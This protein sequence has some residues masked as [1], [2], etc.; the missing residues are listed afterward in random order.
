MKLF[1]LL[2]L[3]TMCMMCTIGGLTAQVSM[4]LNINY[5]PD[6]QIDFPII[7]TMATKISESNFSCR[8]LDAIHTSMEQYLV[9]HQSERVRYM[10]GMAQALIEIQQIDQ[11][12]E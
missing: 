10:A 6:Q 5:M 9:P 2:S 11:E 1:Y 4:L 7:N 12:C 3:D 8:Q